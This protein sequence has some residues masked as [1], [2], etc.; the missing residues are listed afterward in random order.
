MAKRYFLY[1]AAILFITACSSTDDNIVSLQIPYGVNIEIES[2]VETGDEETSRSSLGYSYTQKIM[3]FK[4]ADSDDVGVFPVGAKSPQQQ[5]TP[6]QGSYPE[7]SLSRSFVGPEGIRNLTK[8]TSYIVSKPY[9]SEIPFGYE[10]IPITYE[11]QTQSKTVNIQHYPFSTRASDETWMSTHLGYYE[12]SEAEASAHLGKYDYA[13]SAPTTTNDEGSILFHLKRI[14]AIVRFYIKVPEPIVYDELHLVNRDAKFVV[15]GKLNWGELFKGGSTLTLDNVNNALTEKT[16][17]HAIS[18]TFDNPN[19][20]FN[21]STVSDIT[22]YN[23]D[24]PHNINGYLIAYMMVFPINLNSSSI[25]NCTLYLKGHD[26]EN[27]KYFKA[28]GLSKPTLN[29]NTFYKWTPKMEKDEP[30]TFTAITVQEWE[31]GMKID[32]EKDKGNGTQTW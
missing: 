11:N 26:G 12:A 17:K 21:Y 30:I 22:K 20:N 3:V 27:P 8:N 25:E 28:T 2:N 1:I 23:T 16:E 32:N 13:A 19:T 29:P 31:E 14:G 10:N 6:I 15:N 18:L 7:T 4:W 5:F 9:F 24:D